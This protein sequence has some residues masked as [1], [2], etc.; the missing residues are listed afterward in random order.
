MR[1]WHAPARSESL[2]EAGAWHVEVVPGHINGHFMGTTRMGDDP[3]E[4][5]VDRWGF[6]HDVPN[7]GIIDGSVFV[8][9]SGMNPTAT[10]AALALRTAEHL[11]ERWGTWPRPDHASG[12]SAPSGP[13]I[14]PAAP[15]A[16]PAPA[17]ADPPAVGAEMTPVLRRRFAALA[18]D[19][20]PGDGHMPAASDIGVADHLL[21]E[22]LA[23]RP[24]L[25][26][27]LV[28]VLDGP[29]AQ[30]PGGPWLDDL[31]RRDPAGAQALLTAVA[32]GYYLH[33]DVR[34]RL[35]YPGQV[36]TEVNALEFPAFVA[37]GLLDH[38]VTST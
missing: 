15:P 21:D 26:A 35:G 23:V 9:S 14:R 25:R 24:D 11:L 34:D 33:P 31:R 12:T 37:E 17:P 6:A 32:G 29:E 18:D 30:A 3:A 5:V 19:L 16:A 20:I 8:T 22:V 4:S 27:A 7:L 10:I 13:A 2:R 1:A 38:L 36:P 28:R